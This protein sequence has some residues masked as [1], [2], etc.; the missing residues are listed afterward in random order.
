MLLWSASWA[1]AGDALWAG[2]QPRRAA[3]RALRIRIARRTL[4]CL[5]TKAA[6]CRWREY[7]NELQ[8]GPSTT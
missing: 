4:E 1:V 5:H 8:C 6:M 7:I 3:L 2:W